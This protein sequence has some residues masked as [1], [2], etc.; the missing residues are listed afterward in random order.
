MNLFSVGIKYLG[1]LLKADEKGADS[2][3]L[4]GYCLKEKPGFRF[5]GSFSHDSLLVIKCWLKALRSTMSFT[6]AVY[7]TYADGKEGTAVFDHRSSARDI[8][9]QHMVSNA[10]FSPRYTIARHDLRSVSFTRFFEFLALSLLMLPWAL[11][12]GRKPAYRVNA[13]LLFHEICEAHSLL[14]WLK[15]KQIQELFFYSPFEIDA[16]A[17]YLLIKGTNIKV[18]KIPSP[19]PL[20]THN[21][22]LLSDV[23]VLTYP[24]QTEEVIAF[25]PGIRVGDI[26]HWK[27][28]QYQ[29]YAE[30]YRNITSS[31]APK[32]LGFYSHATWVRRAEDDSNT[33]IGDHESE[34]LLKKL[35]RAYFASRQEVKITVFLH[36]RE[37]KHHDFTTVVSHYDEVF[38]KGR[39]SFA[40][41]GSPSSHLFH[42]VDVGLGALSTILF[43]R[44]FLGYKAVFFP[45]E[46]KVFPLPSSPINIICPTTA[47]SLASA[48]DLALDTPGSEYFSSTGLSRYTKEKW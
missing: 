38:G 44:L 41:L 15:K 42:T 21:K 33:G 22:I 37:K 47:E 7:Y 26:L 13:A 46:M 25:A 39:Y 11:W 3:S 17:L 18:Y 16:N 8:R 5:P 4:A 35:M 29:G 14:E 19:N 32:T 43:E 9:V 12:H 48:L 31:P 20:A 36:P 30:L 28:E 40:P 6:G 24:Y 45:S 2:A 23:L 34:I 10:G 27:P 1:F